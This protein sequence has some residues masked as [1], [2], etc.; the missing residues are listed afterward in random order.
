MKIKKIVEVNNR[1][2]YELLVKKANYKG[3]EWETE[4]KECPLEDSQFPMLILLIKKGGR[5]VIN[6]VREYEYDKLFESD[7]TA[8]ELISVDEYLPFLSME[9]NTSD[10]KYTYYSLIDHKNDCEI[11]EDVSSSALNP[12]DEFND[13]FGIALCIAR[14]H[15]DTVAE[16]A[17]MKYMYRN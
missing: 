16:S 6:F 10:E 4:M 15:N 1:S 14:K 2:E 9:F 5:K 17:L 12:E 11:V 13:L 7:L 8:K 3:Y